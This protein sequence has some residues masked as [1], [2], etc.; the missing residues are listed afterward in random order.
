MELIPFLGVF[1]SVIFLAVRAALDGGDDLWWFSYA[2][3]LIISVVVTLLSLAF[4]NLYVFVLGVGSLI[5]LVSSY[6]LTHKLR[7]GTWT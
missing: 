3:A 7:W 2:A 4:M 6:H 1:V 5:L